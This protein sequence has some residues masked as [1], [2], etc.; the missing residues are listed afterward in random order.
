VEVSKDSEAAMLGKKIGEVIE[1]AVI[2]LESYK[3]QITGL[4]DKMGSPSRKEIDGSRKARVLLTRG[5]GMP[6]AKKGVRM[7]RLIRGNTIGSDTEQINTVITEYGSKSA[8]ELFPKKAE[9]ENKE[10]K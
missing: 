7:R 9:S 10:S 5:L 2:G 6:R 8:E 4:S 1:G 3:L